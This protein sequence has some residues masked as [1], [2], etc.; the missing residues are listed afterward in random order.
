[1]GSRELYILCGAQVK[2]APRS[3]LARDSLVEAGV[4]VISSL[5]RLIQYTQEVVVGRNVCLAIEPDKDE[6]ESGSFHFGSLL[7]V[8]QSRNDEVNNVSTNLTYD[9]AS[10]N[11]LMTMVLALRSVFLVTHTRIGQGII[12]RR[13]G[14]VA[15][16]HLFV[17]LNGGKT[18]LLVVMSYLGYRESRRS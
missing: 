14:Y 12:F 1:N 13:R 17:W 18:L 6:L 11:F 15:W 5:A 7:A 4:S 10:R 2:L 8:I 3:D 9:V 16:V